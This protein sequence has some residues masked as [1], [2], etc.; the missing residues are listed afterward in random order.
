MER[1][2]LSEVEFFMMLCGFFEQI[3]ATLNNSLEGYPDKIC[4]GWILEFIFLLLFLLVSFLLKF[5]ALALS[6]SWFLK[7]S[8]NINFKILSST[9]PFGVL[10]ISDAEKDCNEIKDKHA[11]E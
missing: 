11:L 3:K 6:I 9:T 1:L 8:S 7:L 4:A 2:K 10:S 5:I